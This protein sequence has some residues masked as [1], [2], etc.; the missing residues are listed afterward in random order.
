M[1]WSVPI[2]IASILVLLSLYPQ[3]QMIYT[4]GPVYHGAAFVNDNDESVYIAYLQALIDG[5]PRTNNLYSGGEVRSEE[6]FLS[7]QAFPAYTV[8]LPARLLGVDANTI[9]PFLSILFSAAS[10][11]SLY[12]LLFKITEDRAFSAIAAFAVLILGASAAGYG[13]V[14]YF[15][16]LGASSA[17]LPFLR[18]YTPGLAFPFLF[19]F[20]GSVFI[21]SK[22]ENGS[23]MRNC[24][25]AAASFLALLYS[26]FF[27]WTAA[28]AWALLVF[29]FSLISF[30]TGYRT[31]WKFWFSVI[32]SFLV[33]GIPYFWLLSQRVSSTDSSQLLEST[34]S[35]VLSRPPIW[36]G[37]AVIV[38]LLTLQLTGKVDFER[39]L[40][41]MIASFAFAP[42]ALFNQH[43]ITGYSLQPFHYNLY[44]APY[45]SL[46]AV[47]ILA[48]VCFNRFLANPRPLVF[49]GMISL[50]TVW[51]VVET[52]LAMKY[53][54]N[55]NIVRDATIPVG[56]Q[57]RELAGDDLRTASREVT[58]NSDL[59]QADHQPSI[60]PQGVLWSE[61]LRWAAAISDLEARKRYFAHM[62]YM[63]RDEESLRESLQR[64]PFSFEC[65]AI[66]GARVMPTLT[67]HPHFPNVSE[68]EPIITEFAEFVRSTDTAGPAEPLPSYAVIRGDVESFDFRNIDK[69][70]E[71]RLRESL[72]NYTIYELTPR[73]K[74]L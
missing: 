34:R 53:R 28:L 47:A 9:F 26:Y 71:R 14:K 18:R 22:E 27:L 57:L 67:I 63:N 19:L 4:R 16:S 3:L 43:V 64:C 42:F 24:L 55:A 36:I 10:A 51:G 59:F 72:G 46:I 35:I 13:A 21:A 23:N 52:H 61:H 60:S 37:A 20:A 65:R 40:A 12:W 62:Y 49:A 45:F 48:W 1:R 66:F 68:I 54:F 2:V 50:A 11:L 17:A 5:R 30:K 15:S 70:F 33:F 6:T 73:R 41:V 38:V 58:F 39:R 32:G 25:L 7:I 74:S 56:R 69:W 31:P 8:A 44:A 29:F